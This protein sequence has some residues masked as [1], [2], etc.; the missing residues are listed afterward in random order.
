VRIDRSFLRSRVARR[1]FLAFVLCALAPL[2]AQAWLSRNEVRSELSRQAAERLHAD[3]KSA[4]MTMVERVQYLEADLI[5]L[6]S[7]L[8]RGGSLESVL[9]GIEERIDL[10]FEGLALVE[11]DGSVLASMRG[12]LEALEWTPEERRFLDSGRTACPT[13][14]VCSRTGACAWQYSCVPADKV[15]ESPPRATASASK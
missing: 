4:A 5:V 7:E 14:L 15:C 1:V 12:A 2:A 3:S 8:R 11:H 10:R 13:T 9:A 6:A